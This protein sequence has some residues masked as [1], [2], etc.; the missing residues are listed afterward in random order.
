V[1]ELPEKEEKKT[2]SDWRSWFA[3][4]G[5]R[6]AFAVLVVC[7]L[8]FAVW[9]SAFYKSEESDLE[10]GLALVQI[11]YR[12]QRPFKSRLTA[13]A[14]HQPF[15][16]TRGDGSSSSRSSEADRQRA[17]NNEAARKSAEIFLQDAAKN[18]SDAARAHHA[19]GLLYMAERKLDAAA[20]EFNLAL[21]IEPNNAGIYS[22]LGALYLEKSRLANP[23]D[24]K[25]FSASAELALQNLD[26]AL[27]LNE[28]L[29]EA[30]FNRAL[31]LQKMPEMK[32]EARAAWEKYLEKDARSKWAEEARRNLE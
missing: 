7:V 5:V 14:E 29:P 1:P 15:I 12:G 2:V 9:R 27:K 32:N 11:V 22:D 25:E 21:K 20:N 31:M 13:N 16:D 4:P 18:Q 23:E 8:S 19:L 24:K 30:L 26:N 3:L 17:F 6:L 10:K 28:N